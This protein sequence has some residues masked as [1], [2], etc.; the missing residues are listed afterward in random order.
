MRT[1]IAIPLL[2]IAGSVASASDA[3]TGHGSSLTIDGG[4]RIDSDYRFHL[5]ERSVIF[6]RDRAEPRRVLMR[7]GRLFVDD[8]WVH[9]SPAD[10]RRVHEYERQARAAMPLAQRIGRDAARIAFTSLGEVAAGLSPDPER[11][12]ARLAAARARLEARLAHSVT[13]T[14]FDGAELGNGIA[15]AIREV[16]PSLVGD[17][18]GGAVRAAFA[19]DARRLQ[20]LEDLD[21]DIER[22]IAPQTRDLERNARR[23]C[24]RMEALDRLDDTL[25]Y[26]LPDG[27]SLDLLQVERRH[28][29]RPASPSG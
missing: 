24:R 9:L 5:T 16:L 27:A 21:R 2:I 3:N 15:D 1:W 4:C 11:T 6:T 26:R 10:S 28:H 29:G 8:R 19:G 25:E 12:R 18:V 7:Q 17:V 22:R 14:R 20:E 23:L 13:A